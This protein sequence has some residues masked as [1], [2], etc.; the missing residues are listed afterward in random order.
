MPWPYVW[1]LWGLR[2]AALREGRASFSSTAIS[3]VLAGR[4]TCTSIATSRVYCS[5]SVRPASGGPIPAGSAAAASS[6]PLAE[7]QFP[8][9]LQDWGAC[10]R[11]RATRGFGYCTSTTFSCAACRRTPDRSRRW[12]ASSLLQSNIFE[13][14]RPTSLRTGRAAAHRAVR[15]QA[16][17]ASATTGRFPS[18]GQF[19]N[20]LLLYWL[21]KHRIGRLAVGRLY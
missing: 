7:D 16:V 18:F 6:D 9:G 19:L 3:C 12:C 5:S 1:L 4:T 14:L 10:R 21:K 8:P 2:P 13:T 15:L 17:T 20:M 11:A